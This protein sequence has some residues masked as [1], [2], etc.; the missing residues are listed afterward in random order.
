MESKGVIYFAY[1]ATNPE[2]EKDEEKWKAI[3]KLYPNAAIID[4]QKING[5]SYYKVRIFGCD[6][7]I[8]SEIDEKITADVHDEIS[9]AFSHQ[10]PVFVIRE[11]GKSFSFYEVL[12]LI[13][14]EDE[15]GVFRYAKIIVKGPDGAGKP[16]IDRKLLTD[17]FTI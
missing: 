17:P 7:V 6:I 14:I 10:V 11:T 8:V 12:D 16:E 9:E 2:L 5:Q 13:S 1:C 3:R 4:P 15:E